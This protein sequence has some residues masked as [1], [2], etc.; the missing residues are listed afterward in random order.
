MPRVSRIANVAPKKTLAA[1]E[2]DLGNAGV[3][4]AGEGSV[5]LQETP[6]VE[7]ITADAEQAA[8]LAFNEEKVTVR[9]HNTTDK[10]APKWVEIHVNGKS[11]L[12]WRGQDTTCARKFVEGLARCKPVGYRNE[13][14]VDVDGSRSVRWP[15]SVGLEYPFD[16][17]ED[18]NP[19]GK[20][21]LRSILRQ[22]K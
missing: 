5:I 2:Q 17:V 7:P 14:F 3:A 10:F 6:E 22:T 8:N 4:V 15:T 9:V 1:A 13:E 19:R 12:F 16:V 11:Q 21:W 18:P 20:E